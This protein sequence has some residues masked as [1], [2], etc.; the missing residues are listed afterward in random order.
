M[1]L[2]LAHREDP[3]AAG[4]SFTTKSAVARLGA[5]STL[6]GQCRIPL[7]PS[8]MSDGFHPPLG[9]RDARE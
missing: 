7:P 9:S 2:S 1:S 5:G 8:I 3:C 4:W 6:T